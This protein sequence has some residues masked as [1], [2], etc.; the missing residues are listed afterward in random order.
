MAQ[1]LQAL[2]NSSLMTAASIRE[3]AQVSYYNQQSQQD[4]QGFR[5]LK[6]K[7]D[8]TKVTAS[9]ARV[10]MTELIDFELDLQELGVTDLTETAFFQLRA[11]AEGEA[12]DIIELMMLEPHHRD[13]H[14]YALNCPSGPRFMRNGQYG[15]GY[16][17]Q[18][19]FNQLYQ[20][21]VSALR[22]K[23]GLTDSKIRE[24]ALDGSKAARMIR[25]TA[26]DA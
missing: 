17:R 18:T 5:Q 4:K 8:V 11:V 13:M 6:P 15:S 26:E 19:T 25:N 22:Q 1:M 2:T 10:L 16:A 9:D 24:L 20:D 21:A 3:L 14:I 23:K 7:R 12:K